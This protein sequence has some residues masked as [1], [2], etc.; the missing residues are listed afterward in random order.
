MQNVILPDI[1]A[2]IEALNAIGISLSA[3]RDMHRLLERILSG[4]KEIT[5]ADGGTL[6]LADEQRRLVFEIVRNDS[7]RIAMGGTT[8]QR[9]PFEPI[10]LHDG[11]GQANEH[12]VC[13]YAALKNETI[14]IPDVYSAPGFDFS[15]TYAFDKKTGYRSQS[16]LT[17]P[18]RDHQNEL[19]GVL[20]LLNA[21]GATGE[22]VAFDEQDQGLV[23]SLASQAAVALTNH[24]LIGE[25]KNLLET[26]IQVIAD[27]IDE[28]SPYTG[29]HCRRVPELAMAFA[30]ALNA[31]N[32][33]PFAQWAL[34]EQQL[35]ELKIAA[36]LHDC[37]KITTPVHVVDK[38][39]K[40]ET[41]FDRIEL[42]KLRF[43]VLR[44]DLEIAALRARLE[45]SKCAEVE[46]ELRIPIKEIAEEIA[47]LCKAN[48]GGEFM[49]DEDV[50]KVEKIAQ[51]RWANADGEV[52]PVLTADEAHNLSIRKGT[53]TQKEREVINNH[54]VMTLKMLERLPFPK[55]LKNVSEIAGGHHERMDGKG[56]PRG[57]T[58]DQMSVQARLMG[59]VDIFEALTAADRPYK[60]PMGL[61]Q[62]LTILGKMKLENHVDP[63]LFDVFIDQ[64][65]YLSYAQKHLQAEQLDLADVSTIPGYNR[66]T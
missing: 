27:A 33:G 1:L 5:R 38:A 59:I 60:P 24:R 58:R 49:R 35:Y 44:R 14:N 34:N 22:I 48:I 36:L 40:L 8:G 31:E 25:L 30:E 32:K 46:Q 61:T 29:G 15:G 11:A 43:E 10:V 26:F 57:L 6:Y 23:E 16:I 53:L 19:I 56:Y 20:Q 41:I 37:G 12:N 28:K 63:D 50:A 2:R 45:R 42:V 4:A 13:A 47:F 3:E 7:L 39:T 9:P 65:V 66:L 62:A 17:V 51:R 52:Q 64:K 54:I 55:H 18:M 21:H